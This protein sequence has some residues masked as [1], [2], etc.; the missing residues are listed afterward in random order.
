MQP[1][2]KSKN[3]RLLIIPEQTNQ[4]KHLAN[5]NATKGGRMRLTETACLT[6][7]Y[8]QILFRQCTYTN[9]TLRHVC[10]SVLPM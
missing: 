7:I 3:N 1:M 10:I 2:N 9:E 5:N 6:Y 4:W 8:F